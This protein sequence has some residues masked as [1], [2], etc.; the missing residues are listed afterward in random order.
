MDIRFLFFPCAAVLLYAFFNQYPDAST[1]ERPIV[2]V[3]RIVPPPPLI[4]AVPFPRDETGW[5]KKTLDLITGPC[6]PILP[7]FKAAHDLDA[8]RPKVAKLLR[9]SGGGPLTLE[10]VCIIFDHFFEGWLL[11]DDPAQ[12]ELV[13]KA[14]VLLE[15]PSGDCD[16][17]C[18]AISG[19]ITSIGGIT[20]NVFA[21]DAQG[22]GHAYCE[23]ALGQ[24]DRLE[25]ERYLRAR[26]DLLENTPIYMRE[27][28]NGNLFLNL[29]WKAAHPGGPYFIPVKGVIY[30]PVSDYCT[31]L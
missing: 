6:D 16:D 29:D 17:F 1:D 14:S 18:A 15:T 21:Y 5:W 2:E 12:R 7:A 31:T 23:L 24:A 30:W 26:Y 11:L 20:R 27:D 9:P 10:H 3:S 8:T 22:K 25:I 19:A 4:K 28:A 13:N